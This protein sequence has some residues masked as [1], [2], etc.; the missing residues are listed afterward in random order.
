MPRRRWIVLRIA[1]PESFQDLLIGLLIPL[2]FNGFLQHDETVECSITERRWNP[3]LRTKVEEVLLRFASQFGGLDLPYVVTR[4]REEN[5]NQRWESQVG[6]VEATPRIVIKP[7]WKKLRKKDKGKVVLH[8][9]PKMA[10]GTGHHETTR[11]CLLMLEDLVHDQRAVLDFGCGTGVLAIAAAKLGARKVWG[12]DNDSWA[13]PN[14][15]E[16]VKK[17]RVRDRVR[18]ILGGIDRIPK[19]RFPLIVANIDLPTITATIRRLVGHITPGGVIVFSGVLE[20]DL[21]QLV[22]LTARHRL[23]ALQFIK[24]NEWIAAA[25]ARA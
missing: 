3:R 25:F 20:T 23:V 22:A 8:I 14:A 19:K 7:S 18:I 4:V 16:N 5:W 10:F 11:L 15:R 2:G 1:V 13:I 24:E 6:I 12:I 17:N 21:E 9:D